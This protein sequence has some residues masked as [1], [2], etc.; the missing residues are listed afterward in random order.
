MSSPLFG[1]VIPQPLVSLYQKNVY[2]AT[3]KGSSQ[4]KSGMMATFVSVSKLPQHFMIACA[5]PIKILIMI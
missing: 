3:K 4:K 5:H 2:R 1:N